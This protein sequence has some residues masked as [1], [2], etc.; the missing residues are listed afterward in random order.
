MAWAVED[1]VNNAHRHVKISD[2][3]QACTVKTFDGSQVRTQT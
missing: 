2:G 3:G 1:R